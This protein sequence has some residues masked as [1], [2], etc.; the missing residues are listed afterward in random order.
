MAVGFFAASVVQ[1]RHSKQEPV[2]FA[3]MKNVEAVQYMLDEL[4]TSDS[5]MQTSSVESMNSRSMDPNDDATLLMIESIEKK[6]R[7]V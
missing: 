5:V 3:H 1:C 6:T 4:C 7:R 2:A